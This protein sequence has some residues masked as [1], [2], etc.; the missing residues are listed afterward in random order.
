MVRFGLDDLPDSALAMHDPSTR[1]LRLS[2]YSLAGTLAPEFAY[3]LDWQSARRLYPKGGGYGTD[4]AMR[5]QRGPLSTPMRGLVT[6]RIGGGATSQQTKER[7]AELFA[8]DVDWFI[9][10]SLARQGRSNG[11]L[12]AVQDAV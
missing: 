3:D 6:A 7:P 8:S 9:A 1:T 2:I 4:R 10:S 11:Y 12:S 5:E